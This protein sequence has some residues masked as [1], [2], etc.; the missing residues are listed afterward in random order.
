MTKLL[1]DFKSIIYE[2][3]YVKKIIIVKLYLASF[4]FQFNSNYSLSQNRYI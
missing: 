3:K 4:N 2:E 1:V